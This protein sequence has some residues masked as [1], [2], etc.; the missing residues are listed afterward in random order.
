[1]DDVLAGRRLRLTYLRDQRSIEAVVQGHILD[2]VAPRG[3]YGSLAWSV[4]P[5]L[6]GLTHLVLAVDRHT[7]QPL[8]LLAARDRATQDEAF[9]LIE[10]A[11]AAPGQDTLARRM[12]GMVIMR[13]IGSDPMR[14]AIAAPR[15]SAAICAA[16]REGARRIAGA[17][18]DPGVEQVVVRLKSATLARRI[19]RTVGP[20]SGLAILDL[21][22]VDKARLIDGATH[23]YRGRSYRRNPAEGSARPA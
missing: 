4:R 13:G 6:D 15:G 23:L 11:M 3:Q 20:G 21:R 22:G 19:R 10:T 16:L 14:L 5:R 7:G 9:L 1:M 17:T 18:F 8:G 2:E 12:L